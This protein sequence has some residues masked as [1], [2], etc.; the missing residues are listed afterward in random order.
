MN[1]SHKIGILG[2]S[3]KAGTPVIE[4]SQGVDVAKTLVS[5]G[6]DVTVY[7]PQALENA[8]KMLGES[9]HYAASTQE[10]VD[11]VDFVVVATNWPEFSIIESMEIQHHTNHP[12]YVLDCWRQLKNVQDNGLHI[13]WLGAG[14]LLFSDAHKQAA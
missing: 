9:V 3:Y 13:L 11:A 7:D 4:Q 2:L 10:L 12:K 6:F 8:R 1:T 5:R 14:N